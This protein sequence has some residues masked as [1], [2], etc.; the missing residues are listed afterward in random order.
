MDETNGQTDGR[1]RPHIKSKWKQE[2]GNEH[3]TPKTKR[4]KNSHFKTG[5]I[6]CVGI[7]KEVKDE[8]NRRTENGERKE[9]R[10]WLRGEKSSGEEG[11]INDP[12]KGR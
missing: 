9:G 12:K 10:G 11:W 7:K 8:K 3:I 6:K 5:K 1:N 2:I 4:L